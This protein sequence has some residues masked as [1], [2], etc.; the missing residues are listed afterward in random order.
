MSR[1]CL[2]E[3][4]AACEGELLGFLRHHAPAGVGA[5]DLLHDL[6]LRALGRDRGFCELRNPRA[7]LFEGARN[8]VTDQL[9]RKRETVALQ[10]DLVAGDE[11]DEGDE[12]DRLSR[13]LPRV[14]SELAAEDREAI[15]LCDLGGV[16]QARFA[17]MKGLSLAG[18]KSRVQR[19]RRR[20]RMRLLEACQ[21][22]LDPVG[23]VCCFV[24]PPPAG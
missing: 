3:A 1:P 11:A 20:L 22:Q 19:A 18:A 16:T 23:R 13:C 9:R 4:W 17:A 10:D 14:L 24:P 5:E 12:V 2:L 15:E 21:V 8:L 6:F 7:W